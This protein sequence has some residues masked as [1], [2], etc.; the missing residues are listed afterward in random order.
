MSQPARLDMSNEVVLPPMGSSQTERLE[1]VGGNGGRCG[2]GRNGGSGGKLGGSGVD[3]G[4][5]GDGG[6]GCGDGGEGK[7]GLV[8]G[9]HGLCPQSVQSVPW[10]HATNVAPGPPSSQSPSALY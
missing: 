7:D 1:V 2:A 8:G 3:G 4:V 10:A 9:V 5:G 6:E